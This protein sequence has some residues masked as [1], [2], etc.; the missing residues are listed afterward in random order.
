MPNNEILSCVYYWFLV[1]CHQVKKTK[2]LLKQIKKITIIPQNMTDSGKRSGC[3]M[4]VS[5][6]HPTIVDTKQMKLMFL[7]LL[8]TIINSRDKRLI[9]PEWVIT[10]QKSLMTMNEE[11]TLLIENSVTMLAA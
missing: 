3:R 10:H 5:L 8:L 6:G 1:I 9:L 7:T 2:N 11:R 4:A